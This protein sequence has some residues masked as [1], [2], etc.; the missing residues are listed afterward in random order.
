MIIEIEKY[1]K[2]KILH[3]SNLVCFILF[4]LVYFELLYNVGIKKKISNSLKRKKKGKTIKNNA[5][6]LLK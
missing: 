5:L 2:K 6:F 4:C 3:F 1:K